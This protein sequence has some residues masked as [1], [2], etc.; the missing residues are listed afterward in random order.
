MVSHPRRH[1]LGYERSRYSLR[2]HGRRD[3]TGHDRAL[4][5]APEHRPGV[6]TVRRRG[7][8]VVD[9]IP[10]PLDDRL[11]EL[12]A[13][14]KIGAGR[15]VDRIHAHRLVAGLRAHCVDEGLSDPA[16][17]RRLAGTPGEHH[18]DVGTRVSRR[19]WDGRA[20]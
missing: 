11:G 6:R 2:Y 20:Q 7:L 12:D 3:E 8:D 16:D 1:R 4:R 15:V 13:A 19:G 5:E 9:R 18:L 10:D 17:T 14:A